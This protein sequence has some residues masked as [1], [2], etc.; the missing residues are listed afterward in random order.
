MQ[1]MTVLFLSEGTLGLSRVAEA[2]F[3]THE[4]PGAKVLSA[5]VRREPLPAEVRVALAE[6]D[7]RLEPAMQPEVGE[8]AVMPF[9]VVITLDE[10][11]RRH[12]RSA[13]PHLALAAP[14]REPLTQA[15]TEAE[16]AALI[17]GAPVHIHWDIP[18]LSPSQIGRFAQAAFSEAAQAVR[19]RVGFLV[20]GGYLRGILEQ[21]RFLHDFMDSLAE[22]VILHDNHRKIFL[23][24]KSAETLTGYSRAEVLGRDC[25]DVFHQGFCG[26][27]CAFQDGAPRQLARPRYQVTF[28]TKSGEDRRL[29]MRVT[30]LSR[31]DGV[32]VG[33]IAAISD[34]TEVSRLRLHV[35][36]RNGFHGMVGY[37]A[38]M[39]EVFETIRQVTDSDYPVLVTG[40]SGTGKELVAN[41]I[42]QESRRKAHPFVPINCGALPE[43]ILESELFG[44]VRGAFTGAIRD[45]KG[46][47]E[48]AD[49]GTLF[50]DEVGELTPAFQVKLL[51]V[52][53]EKRFERVGGEQSV[54]VDVRIISA[55]NRDLR[56]MVRE[57]TFREDLYY[58]LCV[59]PIHL[60]PLRERMEDLPLLVT[61]FLETI[62][63]ET[64]KAVEDLSNETMDLL[65]RYR[66]PGNIR[67][68]INT[69]QYGTVRSTG[70]V[71]LPAHLPP[72]IRNQ[73]GE[74]D[75]GVPLFPSIESASDE[76][77]HRRGKLSEEQV[78]RVLQ[79]SG[80][81]KVEAARLLRVGRATLYRFLKDH[82]VE[83]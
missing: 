21:R 45:K 28:R 12:A 14:L 72:E 2:F 1:A 3:R 25:H 29:G 42:H 59:V 6:W 19:E 80:G 35:K 77:V 33:V 22:G 5:V 75:P 49:K 38:R 70:N 51:R 50:L 11:S 18:M 30:P 32:P 31:G 9:D 58:R 26:S 82:P 57:G 62:R 54:S 46:R 20:E 73:G 76:A 47:F 60:P 52:L 39:Q 24:N 79:Q 65:M 67:E 66:W 55:T 43:A 23:F 34:E 8:L 71:I 56:R 53:Q 16:H 10:P 48:L 78:R 74:P 36:E 44:H 81:N 69:L 17:L 37:G 63:Q 15:P 68:L 61:R 40:E 7:I 41:A 4:N 83:G 64:G 27:L 13:L